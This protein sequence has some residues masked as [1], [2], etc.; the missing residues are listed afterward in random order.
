ALDHRAAPGAPAR[1]LALTTSGHLTATRG[2]PGAVGFDERCQRVRTFESAPASPSGACAPRS[3]HASV[4]RTCV[5]LRVK[6]GLSRDARTPHGW[7]SPRGP[8]PRTGP[9]GARI[10][11]RVSPTP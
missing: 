2:T 9:R 3:P 5:T 7:A 6:R 11:P 4:G 10:C 8:G 1:R